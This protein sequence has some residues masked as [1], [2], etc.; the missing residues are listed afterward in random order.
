MQSRT[1][2]IASIKMD[3]PKPDERTFNKDFCVS[4]ASSVKSDGLLHEPIVER[5]NRESIRSLR[6]ATGSTLAAS[7]SAGPRFHARSYRRSSRTTKRN[8]LS[9]QRTF[10]ETT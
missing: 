4:L 10:G 7:F 9:W 3:K 6:A 2:A 1:I 5:S 8:A